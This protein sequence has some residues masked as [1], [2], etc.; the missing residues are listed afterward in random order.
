[1]KE[2]RNDDKKTTNANQAREEEM[3]LE[4]RPFTI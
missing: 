2:A 4:M 1:M 3:I